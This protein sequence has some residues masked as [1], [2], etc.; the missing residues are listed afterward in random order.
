MGRIWLAPRGAGAGKCAKLRDV[1][2]K[3]AQI[4]AVVTRCYALLRVGP[5]LDA[6]LASQARHKLGAPSGLFA[7]AK[8]GHI[9]TGGTNF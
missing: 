6:N 4:K 1:S 2:R 5:F 8:R 7:C 3:F 9:V